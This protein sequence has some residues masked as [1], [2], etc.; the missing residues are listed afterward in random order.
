MTHPSTGRKSG[1]LSYIGGKN[2][3]ARQIIEILPPHTAYVE[4]FAGGAQVFFHKEPSRVE[5]L[6]DLNHDVTNFFRVAQQH[7]EELLRYL[8][9]ILVGREWFTL[10]KEQNPSCLT[11]IQRAARFFYLQ[12]NC[13]AG[14]VNNPRYTHSVAGPRSFNP[15]HLREMI[16][17]AHARLCRVQIE[18]LPYEAILE[19]FDRPTT[20]FY[21]DPPYWNRLL[22][23]FNFT[24]DD[25]AKLEDRLRSIRG[26][27][28][29]SL[30]DRTEVRQLFRR[31][32]M[33][34][35][36]LAYTAQSKAGKRFQELLI[37]NFA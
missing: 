1:P 35:I 23:K 7:H 2:R 18:C 33:R 36:S 29:L 14:L 27:F 15:A 12:K 17:R 5:V 26:K 21:L 22:Y 8:Q 19:R 28:I 9:F 16:E 24:E 10:F 20:L 6:N 11:D 4:A 34:E 3:I 37:T 31:F 25:F 32:H 13:Y 30:D